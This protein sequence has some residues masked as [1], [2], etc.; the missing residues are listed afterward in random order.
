MNYFEIFNIKF[1]QEIDLDEIEAKYLAFQQQFHPD[2]ASTADIEKSILIN[3]AFTTL[4]DPI[5]R[6]AYILKENGIDILDD[7]KA[8]KVKPEIL[9]QVWDLQEQISENNDTQNQQLKA[10]LKEKITNLFT[11]TFNEIKNKNFD[12]AAQILI[13]TKY[14]N[15]ILK[16]L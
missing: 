9:S 15:K 7:T 8:P 14:F 2:K 10:T 13:T 12:E 11:A 16:D 6:Y 3:D 5:K 1:D 4:Q